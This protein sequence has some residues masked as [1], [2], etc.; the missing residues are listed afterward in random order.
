M[1]RVPVTGGP[2]QVIAREAGWASPLRWS[3]DGKWIYYHHGLRGTHTLRRVSATGGTSEVLGPGGA[4]IGFSPDGRWLARLP[5]F[6][7]RA[8]QNVIIIS[9]LQGKDAARFT[10]PR[11]MEAIAWG[12]APGQ[13]SI[14]RRLPRTAVHFVDLNGQVSELVAPTRE[15]LGIRQ[16]PSGELIVRYGNDSL[17][18]DSAH[19]LVTRTVL[20]WRERA[21]S[22]PGP[23]CWPLYDIIRREA[24]ADAFV[25]RVQERFVMSGSAGE[26]LAIPPDAIADL[27]LLARLDDTTLVGTTQSSVVTITAG[28]RERRTLFTVSGART[29]TPDLT[30][31]VDGNWLATSSV[32]AESLTTRFHLIAVRGATRREIDAVG[33]TMTPPIWDPRGRFLVYVSEIDFRSDLWI[34]TLSGDAP[35]RLTSAEPSGVQLCCALARD[36]SGVVYT[37]ITGH[38]VS[39]WRVNVPPLTTTKKV[40]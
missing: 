26:R 37:T 23:D 7:R 5:P 21:T 38:E 29:M 16:V 36:G 4:V 25:C 35:R 10:I 17:A 1:V 9:D 22:M 39:L 30:A 20:P 40:P 3:P 8:P 2:E 33:I 34:E 24:V 6:P 12:P 27:T 18:T 32:Q 28:S 19:D 11:D 31:S 13:L 15:R 14:L